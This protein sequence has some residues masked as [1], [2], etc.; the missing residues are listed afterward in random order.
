VR[1]NYMKIKELKDEGEA[2]TVKRP[3]HQLGSGSRLAHKEEWM[4]RREEGMDMHAL[5]VKICA[6]V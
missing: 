2:K 4:E 5:D 1:E 6:C 3:I